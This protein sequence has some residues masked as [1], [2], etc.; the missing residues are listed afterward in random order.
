MA[1]LSSQ[2]IKCTD[3]EGKRVGRLLHLNT[4]LT[5]FLP[6]SS[7]EGGARYEIGVNESGGSCLFTS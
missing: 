7:R 5:E 4:T 3:W 1:G 6:R 2:V